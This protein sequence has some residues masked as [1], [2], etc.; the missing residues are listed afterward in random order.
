[1]EIAKSGQLRKLETTEGE[2]SMEKKPLVG[3]L[4]SGPD[5]GRGSDWLGA[6]YLVQPATHKEKLLSSVALLSTQP[7][8]II[9]PGGIINP[10]RVAGET[11]SGS[12]AVTAEQL[13]TR[14]YRVVVRFP[15]GSAARVRRLVQHPQYA[16]PACLVQPCG[17]PRYNAKNDLTAVVVEDAAALAGLVPVCLPDPGQSY[18]ANPVQVTGYG[19]RRSGRQ[20]GLLGPLRSLVWYEQ[21]VQRAGKVR[22][23]QAVSGRY[24]VAN[25]S[26]C[27]ELSGK[28]GEVGGGD[29]VVAT[30]PDKRATLL[31]LTQQPSGAGSAALVTASRLSCYLSWLASKVG[32]QA[33]SEDSGT[34]WSTSCPT[35][36]DI[37]L[38]A[39]G[40]HLATNLIQDKT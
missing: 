1:M 27:L 18:R 14:G 34:G 20:G 12:G 7:P 9:A 10:Y 39:L 15:G 19:V 38:G 25:G 22:A 23:C 8:V 4:K 29:L 13:A 28:K 33:E 40:P 11:V 2:V 31:G 5:C 37:A 6:L 3:I 30:G 16:G 32:L 26:L 36:Q 35:H 21:P 24:A 17:L